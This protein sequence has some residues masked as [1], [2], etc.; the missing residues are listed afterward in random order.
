MEPTASDGS[1]PVDF[2]AATLPWVD[3]DDFETE[4]E[5]RN[6]AGE[7]EGEEA[8]ALRQFR[9]R[10][11]VAFPRLL[12]EDQVDAL[13]ADH[14]RAWEEGWPVQALV[15]GRGVVEVSGLPPRGE[16]GS[17][18][19]RLNDI[20]DVS[21]AARR[22]MLDSRI[23]RFLRAY[24]AGSPVAMQSLF[25]EFGSEQGTHQD[26]PYVQSQILSHLVGCWIACDDVDA[27][28]GPLFY[29]P[30]S[31]RLPK[32][33]WGDGSLTFDGRDHS[34]V[35]RF[36]DYLE[37]AAEQAGL[38]RL[39]FHAGRGDVFLWHGALVHGGSPA[40]DPKKTRRSLV[41]HYSSRDAYPHDRRFPHADPE[42]Y[43]RNGG[44]VYLPQ[45]GSRG[46]LQRLAGRVKRA[47]FG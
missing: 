10:G 3:R 11:Y 21:D 24:F 12:A 16:L 8:E 36:A 42:L 33:D 34:Q 17:H 32:F 44:Y 28:N 26:F 22:A 43:E 19:Y 35:E 31:H 30:G 5:H 2:D 47:L 6:A 41:V 37:H 18:H 40:T 20:Q 27:D 9:T 39:T 23:M 1:G 4:L 45:A 14:D 7:L 25:F 38:E 13:V 15:E 29:Y 46:P